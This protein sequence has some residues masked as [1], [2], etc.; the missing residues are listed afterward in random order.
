MSIL[1][2][3]EKTIEYLKNNGFKDT[4][5]TVLER[6]EMRKDNKYSYVCPNEEELQAQRD[7]P[8]AC[9]P[10]ISVIVPCYETKPVYLSDMILSV[11]EQTYTNYELIIVDASKTN[12][13]NRLCNEMRE[14]YDNIRY[15]RLEENKGI[16]ENTNAAIE[17]AQGEYIALLDHDDMLTPDALYRMA[18]A[19]NE[20]KPVLVYSDEDKT[21]EYNETYFEKT[22]K[23]KLNIDRLLCNNYICHFCMY[24]G[25]VLRK[26]RLRPEYDGAQD[27]DLLLRTVSYVKNE[28]NAEYSSLIKYIPYVLYH[29]RSF[30]GSSAGTTKAKEYAYESGIRCVEDYFLREKIDEVSVVKDRHPGFYRTEYKDV[31]KSRKDIGA[32]GGPVFRKGRM[33]GGLM[34]GKGNVIFKGIRKGFSGYMN[35]A[36]IMQAAAVLDVRN[37]KLRDDLT[38]VFAESTGYK[39]PITREEADKM[40]DEEAVK[41]SIILCNKLKNGGISL[42]YDPNLNLGE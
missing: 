22:S 11:E 34:D 23:K 25:D 19:V 13:V 36:T 37:I 39:Y 38:N 5:M 6:V 15:K 1:L 14:T 3:M 21:D 8:P 16:S 24:R 26:L 17:M 12:H 31:F 4:F 30:G 10:F 28:C 42:L 32:V 35:E 33:C 9:Q 40:S 18:E 41:K 29:W 20:A 27:H 2:S 7:N